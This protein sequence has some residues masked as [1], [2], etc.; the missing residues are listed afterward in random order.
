[1][2]DEQKSPA[3]DRDGAAEETAVRRRS[4]SA[5]LGSPRSPIGPRQGEKGWD[6]GVMLTDVSI[7]YPPHSINRQKADRRPP[8]WQDALFQTR[9][10]AQ[11]SPHL[12]ARSHR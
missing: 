5:R 3:P 12:P 4:L 2:A 11:L 10:L 9:R 1:M 8:S 6:G 7:V